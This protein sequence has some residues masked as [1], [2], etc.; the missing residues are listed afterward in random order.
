MQTHEREIMLDLVR[1]TEAAALQASRYMGN[2]DKEQVDGAAVEAMRDMLRTV[3]IRG[4]VV[5]GEGEKDHA[6]MLY[7]GESIGNGDSSYEVDIAV[8]P[9]EGTRLV[10]NGLPNALSILILAAKGA[11]RPIPA[12]YMEKIV[13]GAEARDRIDLDA[14]VRENLKVVAASLGK[15]VT[16]MTVSILDRPRHQPLIEEIRRVGARI[17]LITDG[18]VAAGIAACMEGTGVDM[19]MGI[20]GATEGVLTAAAVKC[21]GGEIQ[22]R[23]WPRDPE[24]RQSILKHMEERDLAT[25]YTADD[26]AKG[27][28]LI[29]AATGV[30]DGDL[31]KGVRYYGGHATT[32]SLV[33]RMSTGTIRKIETVHNIQ[34]K[35]DLYQQTRA[36]RAV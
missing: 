7:I 21:L 31:L 32:S 30:T 35:S 14:P 8:D 27:D 24:E 20:G 1:V 25:I 13:V 9:V 3:N 29:F 22:A 5:I 36:W 16:D 17:R 10:A 12:F 34:R 11:V 28:S 4:T 18:D 33:M 15:R 26:L 19:L 2:G 6:P 23:I